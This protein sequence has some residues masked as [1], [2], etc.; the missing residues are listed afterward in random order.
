MAMTTAMQPS[1]A[2]CSIVSSDGAGSFVRLFQSIHLRDGLEEREPC[3]RGPERMSANP[4]TNMA[5]EGRTWT[6]TSPASRAWPF[7][8]NRGCPR[9]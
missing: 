7:Q 3:G 1:R 6:S 5:R 4:A 8:R 9:N 2:S